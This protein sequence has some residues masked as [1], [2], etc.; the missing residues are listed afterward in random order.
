M[1]VEYFASM[2]DPTLEVIDKGSVSSAHPVPLLF[3]HGAWN[4]AWCWDQHFLNYFAGNGYR[5]VALSL[6]G[7][8][9]SSADKPLRSC[10]LADY[11]ADV[12][13][14]AESLPSRPV[15]IG[16]SMGGLVVQKYLES[17]D[18]PAG[19][20][21]AS[22]PPQ[23]SFAS[24]MRWLRR[25]PSHFV[26]LVIT[27]KSLAFVNTPQLARERFFSAQ[28]PEGQVVDYAG[29][30]QEES[31][32]AGADM[33]LLNL[34]RT[35]KVTTPLLVLGAEADGAVSLREVRST[36]RTYRTQAEIFGGIGH[37]M[38]LESGWAAVAGRIDSWLTDRGL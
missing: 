27:D 22:M 8:G 2:A 24:G 28:T 4:S 14:V 13:S 31:A 10:S 33:F 17:H 5:A 26:R 21:M 11:V 19:V 35:K 25:H 9:R 7:H 34:P 15:I 30:L 29:R 6:R 16:H 38:M 1:G 20:L 32:R 3:V 23:G 36:A 18:A 37:A 12:G